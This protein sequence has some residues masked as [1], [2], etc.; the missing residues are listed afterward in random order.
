M[1]SS[2]KLS[3]SSSTDFFSLEIEAGQVLGIP[4]ISIICMEA[5]EVLLRSLMMVLL[6]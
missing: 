1:R 5:L 6:P 3:P 2:M 4:F